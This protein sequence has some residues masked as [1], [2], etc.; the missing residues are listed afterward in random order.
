[1]AAW[2]AIKVD[3][4]YSV[5]GQPEDVTRGVGPQLV[6]HES[7]VAADICHYSDGTG[8]LKKGSKREYSTSSK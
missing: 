4:R 6:R 8:T 1:M 7:L 3:E 5:D 2:L